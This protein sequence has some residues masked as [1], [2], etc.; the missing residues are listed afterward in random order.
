MIQFFEAQK[1]EAHEENQFPIPEMTPQ[2]I[3][4]PEVTKGTPI[5][6]IEGALAEMNRKEKDEVRDGGRERRPMIH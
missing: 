4:V 1:D 5:E 3:N 2:L 6:A